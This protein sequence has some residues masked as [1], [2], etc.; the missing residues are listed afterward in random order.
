MPNVKPTL[1]PEFFSG[2]SGAAQDIA[3]YFGTEVR[4]KFD[5]AEQQSYQEAAVLAR[6]NEQFTVM[7]TAIQENQADRELYTALGRTRAEVAGAGFS[8]SGSGLDIL[9]SC[10]GR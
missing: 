5:I 7:S 3:G 2:L 6:Q 1:S 4:G 8:L 10:A 9:P